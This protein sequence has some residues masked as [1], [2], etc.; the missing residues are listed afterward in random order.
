MIVERS[1]LL[2]LSSLRNTPPVTATTAAALI[3]LHANRRGTIGSHTAAVIGATI[4]AIVGSTVAISAEM[5]LSAHDLSVLLWVIGIS[6]VMGSVGA[7][8]MLRRLQRSFMQLRRAA[9]KIGAGEVVDPDLDGSKEFSEISAQL[10]DT[11]ARLAASRGEVARLDASRRQL[12]AWVSHDL[13][14]PLAGI[15]AMAEALEEGVAQSPIEY[16]RQIRGQVDAVNLMVDGLFELSKIQSG[17]LKLNKEPVVLL[18]LI[19]DVVSDMRALA[20]ERVIRIRQTG[21]TDHMLLADPRELSRVIANLLANSIRYAP[22]NSE[23]RVSADCVDGDRL[24]LSVVDQGPGSIRRTL[25]TCS[26]WDG[27]RALHARKV[28]VDR[29]LVSVWRLCVGLSKLTAARFPL[30]R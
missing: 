19:S 24:I 6:A 26:T 30:H 3:F 16:I 1:S 29:E 15:R 8:F 2:G 28:K 7:W 14:T 9:E 21:M 27:G 4:A 13:R 23:I 10:A 11:S 22:E 25:V 20:L 17:A 5:Y 12:V 18:D